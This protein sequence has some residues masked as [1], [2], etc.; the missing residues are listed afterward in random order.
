MLQVPAPKVLG[1]LFEAL[2]GAVFVDCGGDL[3]LTWRVLQPF[4]APHLA[5]LHLP[6][7]DS[8]S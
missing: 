3:E 6:L 5:Q 1:D 7:P 2:T 4:L 8:S